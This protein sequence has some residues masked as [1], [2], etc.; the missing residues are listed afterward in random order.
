MNLLIICVDLSLAGGEQSGK[1]LEKIVGT[2]F[3]FN[4]RFILMPIFLDIPRDILKAVLGEVR[5]TYER[6][7]TRTTPSGSSSLYLMYPLPS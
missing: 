4:V 3:G 1:A 5:T 6:I 2:A 7:V